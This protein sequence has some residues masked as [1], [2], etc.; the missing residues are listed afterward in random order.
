MSKWYDKGQLLSYKAYFNM[1]IG[2]RG[3]GKTYGFKTWC[4]DDFIKNNKQFVWIRRYGTEI[5]EMKKT[6]FDDIASKYP[7]YKFAIKGNKKSGKIYVDKKVAGYYFALT[8][9]SIAKSSSYPGVDKI[10]F[11][12]FLII[13]NTYRYLND[14]VVLLLEF[15]ETIF[16]DREH[17][18]KAV[19]PRGIYLLGNNVTIANPYFLY[20]NVRPFKQRFYHDK[21]RGILVEQFTNKEFVEAKKQSMIG[22]LTANTTYAE[23]SIENKS[24]LDN[25]RF[26]AKKPNTATFYLCIDY[27][28]KTYGFWLDF[29]N[30][31]IFV[32]YQFDPDSYNHYSLTKDD[33]SINTFLIKN[34]SNT[35]IKNIVWL[36]RNGCMYFENEQIKSQVY[37][38]LS[39][40]VR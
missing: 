6:F 28:D 10:V 23:Y 14:E 34:L 30:G 32:N 20:F 7:G 21:N 1:L 11:D 17:D 2:N 5:D 33:H 39:Y 38:I 22:K 9:S 3:G 40:F 12:E 25:D 16:R 18:P 26:I 35:Y 13:G 36:F 29:K 19:K 24:Y 31:N 27:K 8:T 15:M 4:I 37:E